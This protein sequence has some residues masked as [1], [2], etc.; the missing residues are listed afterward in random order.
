MKKYISVIFLIFIFM[1]IGCS[2][3]GNIKQA[4]LK[5]RSDR[6]LY[7]EARKFIKKSPEKARMI[8]KEIMHLYPD[9]IYARRAKIGVADSHFFQRGIA[10]KIM[11]AAEYNEYVSF[12]P[13][14]PDAVYAKYQAAICFLK[15]V[16]SSGR[17]QTNTFKAIKAFNEV[18]EL[19]PDSDEAEQSKKKI[20][21][22]RKKL[23]KHY[24]SIGYYNMRFKAYKGAVV[25][26]KQVMDEYPEFEDKEKLYFYAGKS[27]LAMADFD[28]AISFFNKV[29]ETKGDSKYKKKS[30]KYLSKMDI[31]RKK[32]K[33]RKSH[34][35]KKQE[36]II[37]KMTRKQKKEEEKEK[38]KK[39]EKS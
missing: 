4:D 14:S 20:V 13:N 29:L 12:Y 16:K 32:F 7:L 19:Y 30:K 15:Q 2:K 23:A 6:N 11:A 31:Y 28:T 35:L 18:I 38:E 24:Y 10:S 26:F 3:K 27:Y 34:E 17:D 22:L 37:K 1:F 8:F 21:E 36:K 39:K 33:I 25:R 9:S 5:R